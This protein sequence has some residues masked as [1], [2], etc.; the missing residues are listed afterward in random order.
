MNRALDSAWDEVGNWLPQLVG[1]LALLFLGLGLAWLAGLLTARLLAGAGVDRLASRYGVHES[2]GRS[3]G[4]PAISDLAG[5]VVRVVIALVVVVGAVSTVGIG[6]VQP[7]LNE[8]L[9]YVPRV[10]AAL[11]LVAA[12]VVVG[13]LVGAWIERLATQLDIEAP[14]GR[15]ACAVVIAVFGLTALAQLGVPTG[16]VTVLASV[17]LVTIGL[18]AA[19]AFGLGSRELARELGAGRYITTA[20]SLGDRIEVDAVEGEIVAFEQVAV[21]LR[22]PDGHIVRLPNHMLVESAVTTIGPISR[23]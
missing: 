16:L 12:G 23:A 1:A 13:K 18:T 9:L 19:L 22:R 3:E 4:T 20:Y 11:V 15:T 6:G 10:L 14:L 7:T 17:V 8:L 21:V 5:R 2:I